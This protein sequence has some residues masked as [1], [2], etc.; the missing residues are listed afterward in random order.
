MPALDGARASAR[1]EAENLADARTLSKGARAPSRRATFGKRSR[2]SVGWALGLFVAFQ[3]AT[4]WV[5]DYARPLVRFPSARSVL[6]V[7]RQEPEPPAF[8]VFGSSRAGA[9]VYME[10][11]ERELAEPGRP[12]PR[13]VSLAVPAGDAI[14]MEFLLDQ[15]L[16]TGPVPKWAVI[17][18]SPETVNAENAWWMPLH[19]LRQLNWEHVPTHARAA[20]KGHAAWPY[21]ESRLVPT[22]TYRKQIVAESKAAVRD[23]RSRPAASPGAAPGASTADPAAPL[24]WSAI[25]QAP[26]RPPDDQLFENSRVGAQTIL[27]RSLTPYRIGGPVVDA[28]ERM[29]AKCRA[30]GTHVVLLGVPTCSAHRAEYTPPIEAAFD[31]YIQKLIAEYGCRYADG[32]DWVPDSLFLDTLHVDVPGGKLFT[33]RLARDVLKR[34]PLN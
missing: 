11:L 3:A 17:E 22:Y 31:E 9:A 16:R 7:A 5:L 6:A 14:S 33:R 8:A 26:A 34:L 25:I 29:L 20:V 24:N 32:R 13:V 28:L 23:W 18:L 10:D 4:G 12:A 19:V 30:A 1:I 15:L 27:R 2:R 21:L